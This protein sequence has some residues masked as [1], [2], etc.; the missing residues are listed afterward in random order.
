MVGFWPEDKQ[1]L[2]D[3][4]VLTTIILCIAVKALPGNWWMGCCAFHL[5]LFLGWIEHYDTW[6]K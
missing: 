1:G 6:R 5:L 3:R 4:M 2:I